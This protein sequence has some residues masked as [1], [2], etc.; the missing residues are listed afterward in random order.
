MK[1]TLLIFGIILF[2]TYGINAQEKLSKLRIGLNTSL[3]KNLSSENIAFDKYT[4]Y[5]ADYNKTNYRI[6]LNLEYEIK[7]RLSINTA[8][9]Y[10]N[11][12]FTGTYYCAVC[13]FIVPPSPQ[14]IDFRFIEV[15]LTLKYYFLPNKIRLFGEVGL[16]NLFSLN[17]EVTDNSYGLGVKFG[18]GI[19]YNLSKKIA[20]QMTMDYN[21]V[22]S[23]LY[24]ESDF[25]LKSFAFGI[26]IMKRI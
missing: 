3:E 4:G 11:K 12:D 21:N 18:G 24:K 1:K 13:F 23:K 17:K 10:S 5:S 7:T 20:L 15:P 25:K 8:I 19:E 9:N 16:N 2:F 22:I 6:G 14:N 26:G